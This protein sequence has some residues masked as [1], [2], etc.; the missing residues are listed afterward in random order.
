MSARHPILTVGALGGNNLLGEEIGS[1]LVPVS[2][3]DRVER[4]AEAQRSDAN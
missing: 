1:G 3:E 2:L 4:D